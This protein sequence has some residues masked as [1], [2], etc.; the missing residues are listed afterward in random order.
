MVGTSLDGGKALVGSDRQHLEPAGQVML[1]HR[2][3]LD[4]QQVDVA[5]EYDPPF[6]AT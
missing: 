6:C 4:E 2:V 5:G 3:D 1:A